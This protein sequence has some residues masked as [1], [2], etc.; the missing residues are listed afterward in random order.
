MVR[1]ISYIILALTVVSCGK[2][3]LT[4]FFV[5]PGDN[6]DERFEQSMK[7]TGGHPYE[8]VESDDEYIAY[9]CSDIHLDESCNNLDRF[10]SDLR[11]DANSSLGLILGDVIEKKGKMQVFHNALEWKENQQQYDRPVFVIPGNHDMAF[12]QWKD[13]KKLFGASVYYV[14]VCFSGGKDLIIALDSA[15]GT[16]GYKQM[17][18]LRK[19]LETDRA[20]YRYCIVISHTNIFRDGNSEVTS[21][22]MPLEETFALI[23]IFNKSKVDMVFQGHKHQ[24][25]DLTIKNVR[26]TTIGA[27]EEDSAGPEYLKVHIS[28]TGAEY[29]WVVF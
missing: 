13:F 2:Y 17:K 21:G 22:N 11:N 23:D 16:L 6:A 18:W 27:L 3:D 12:G 4:G 19:K 24:R 5:S 25:E 7:Y 10:M 8:V 14:E 26:Y 9:I 28:Q 20:S 29:E 1:R 15:S